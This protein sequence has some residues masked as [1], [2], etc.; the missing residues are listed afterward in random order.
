VLDDGTPGSRSDPQHARHDGRSAWLANARMT[1]LIVL[2]LV[3]AWFLMPADARPLGHS[4]HSKSNR[5][6][7]RT[8]AR[9]G[10]P[11]QAGQASPTTRPPAPKPKTKPAPNTTK[12]PATSAAPTTTVPPRTTRTAPPST[13]APDT[14]AATTVPDKIA[15]ELFSRLNAERQARGLAPLKW[16]GSLANMATDWTRHMASSD[17]FTHRDLGEAS[18][19]PGIS[20]FSALGENIAWV[21][22][23]P[24]EAYQL[25]IGW[26]RSDGHRSNMLQPGFDSVGIAVVCSDGKA[27]ATQN[28]GRMDDS[29]APAMRNSTPPEN[30]IVGTS[31]DGLHC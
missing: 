7:T 15:Q 26:M 20:K 5:E 8:N 27:W 29:D 9:V 11:V 14:S 25:H 18:R 4:G 31:P 10:N 6:D 22:G 1:V 16:D 2:P 21:E 3:L 23:Y 30:P 12:A 24:N 28:F 19:L 13:G 17:D